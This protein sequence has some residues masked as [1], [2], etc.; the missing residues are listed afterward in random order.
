MGKTVSRQSDP[1]GDIVGIPVGLVVGL[2]IVTIALSQILGN[3]AVPD[4]TSDVAFVERTYSMA[5]DM[6]F[7]FETMHEPRLVTSVVPSTTR[8]R[9]GRNVPSFSNTNNLLDVPSSKLI[10]YASFLTLTVVST[11]YD[12]FEKWR[13]SNSSS[14]GI[15]AIDIAS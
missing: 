12:G 11:A 13:G 2:N 4:A 10:V 7:T 1:S 15:V 9:P 6:P 8:G 14:M 5:I 3:V